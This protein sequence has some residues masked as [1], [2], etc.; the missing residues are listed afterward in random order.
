MESRN[1]LTYIYSSS[2]QWKYKEFTGRQSF[3]QIV[4]EQWNRHRPKDEFQSYHIPNIKINSK[5]VTESNVK[6]K[7]SRKKTQ[8][9]VFVALV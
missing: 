2:F 8:E 3:Q 6:P 1:E 4:L 7:T 9:K 5:C